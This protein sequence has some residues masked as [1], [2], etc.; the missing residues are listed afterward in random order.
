[1]DKSIEQEKPWFIDS[2]ANIM[3]ALEIGEVTPIAIE[4]RIEFLLEKAEK[5]G[6]LRAWEKCKRWI[7]SSNIMICGDAMGEADAKASVNFY[8]LALTK[9]ADEM[10]KKLKGY[11]QS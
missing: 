10:I 2:L 6:E 3:E 11:E 4:L 8:K 5:I 1:M 7:E 9:R